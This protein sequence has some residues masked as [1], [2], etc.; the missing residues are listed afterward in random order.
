MMNL[1]RFL[2]MFN[3]KKKKKSTKSIKIRKMFIIQSY[4][5]E[6]VQKND[7]ETFL[8]TLKGFRNDS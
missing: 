6:E 5:A 1:T 4:E 7:K 2:E 8:M 3:Q